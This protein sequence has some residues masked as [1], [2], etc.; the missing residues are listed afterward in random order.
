MITPIVVQMQ[1]DGWTDRLIMP[2]DYLRLS[3]QERRLISLD[4]LVS[5]L[6][7]ELRGMPDWALRGVLTATMMP[8]FCPHVSSYGTG[9]GYRNRAFIFLTTIGAH[10]WHVLDDWFSADN[11]VECLS[12][13][14]HGFNGG[15]G[16]G[17][18]G[19]IGGNGGGGGAYVKKL[20]VAIDPLVTPDVVYTIGA[21][22]TTNGTW[23]KSTDTVFAASGVGR[24]GGK[25]ANSN[26]DVKWNGGDGGVGAGGGLGGQKVEQ[27]LVQSGEPDPSKPGY[28]PPYWQTVYIPYGGTGGGGAGGGGAA[29]QTIGGATGFNGSNGSD[30]PSTA[31]GNPGAGGDGGA[32]SGGNGPGGNGTKGGAGKGWD[33]TH[34]SGGGGAGGAG[35]LGSK[36]GLIGGD[37]GPYGG[38]GGGGGG[39]GGNGG[40]NKNNRGLGF[41]GLIVITN[42]T[43][44]TA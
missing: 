31:R 5:W 30:Y 39:A 6:P 11:S 4:E 9:A 10:N 2:R 20:N 41:Q 12:N 3:T 27:Y 33:E 40:N 38:G 1:I 18:N 8:G 23:F 32:P 19:G 35:G 17:L 44:V 15:D 26:G 43:T 25:A 29:G 28:S 37:G 36:P 14:A 42:N 16:V 24:N 21:G 7:R 13:G 22:N 34:G